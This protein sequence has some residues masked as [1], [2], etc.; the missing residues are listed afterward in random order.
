MKHIRDQKTRI[1][2]CRAVCGADDKLVDAAMQS[3][4]DDCRTNPSI[5]VGRVG[6]VRWDGRGK[7]GVQ[8][9]LEPYEPKPIEILRKVIEPTPGVVEKKSNKT[10]RRSTK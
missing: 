3:D 8:P 5:N 9:E 1:P 10:K 4:C 7:L 2:V 6:D